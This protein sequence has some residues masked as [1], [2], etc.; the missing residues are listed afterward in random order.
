MARADWWVMRVLIGVAVLGAYMLTSGV[1]LAH[2]QRE[3]GEYQ[4]TVG[5]LNE[6]A[7]VEEPNGLDLRI[8]RGSGE[9]GEPVEGAV[10][11]LQAEVIYGSERRDLELRPAFGEPGAYLSDFI[12]TAEGAYTF[13]IF[14]SI[15]GTDID[16]EFTSGP[17]SFSEV[18]S[19]SEMAFPGEL[20][21]ISEVD[22]AASDAAATADS[23]RTLALVALVAGV[24]GMILA[25]GGTAFARQRTRS[26]SQ[27]IAD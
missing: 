9:G 24:F 8:Q 27:H 17:E 4:L 21:T 2:E 3:V 20:G 26:A 11:T 23:A 6:P 13:H 25:L 19:R 16:E 1:A 10:Q 12:P 18:L 7:L 15:D 22:E 14:G 5:F